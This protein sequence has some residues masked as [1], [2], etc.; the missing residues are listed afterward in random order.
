MT[1]AYMEGFAKMAEECG[2]VPHAKIERSLHKA[3][4]MQQPTRT[5]W[6]QGVLRSLMQ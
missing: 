4:N 6:G 1:E 5:S 3:M 2:T